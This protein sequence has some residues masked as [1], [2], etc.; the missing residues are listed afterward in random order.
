MMMSGEEGVKRTGKRKR[1]R[2][3]NK[4]AAAAAAAGEKVNKAGHPACIQ[5]LRSADSA[6]DSGIMT[7]TRGWVLRPLAGH[8]QHRRHQHRRHRGA[9]GAQTTKTM[10]TRLMVTGAIEAR[11]EAAVHDAKTESG[12]EIGSRL[13]AVTAAR[14]ARSGTAAGAADHEIP[15]VAHA[16]APMAMTTITSK[17]GHLQSAQKSARDQRLQKRAPAVHRLSGYVTRAGRG[18]GPSLHV[19]TAR[20]LK[21]GVK[22]HNG[23]QGAGGDTA[24]VVVIAVG[25]TTALGMMA[26][27]VGRV[28][29]LLGV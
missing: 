17:T 29:V 21:Q 1:K 19:A 4:A 9:E 15:A 24:A 25:R 2:K 13:G 5:T 27:R 18:A 16:A 26:K 22:G 8:L 7:T 20:G 11:A 3:R 12:S 6:D 10:P 23:G 14:A 28:V